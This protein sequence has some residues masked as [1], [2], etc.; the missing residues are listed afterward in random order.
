MF[1]VKFP[2]NV[3]VVY[4]APD[5]VNK[6]EFKYTKQTTTRPGGYGDVKSPLICLFSCLN[7]TRLTNA[8]TKSLIGHRSDL[9]SITRTRARVVTALM[10]M[11]VFTRRATIITESLW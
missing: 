10:I 8:N 9:F 5:M 6:D 3:V 2:V 11:S 1:I 4:V 7:C